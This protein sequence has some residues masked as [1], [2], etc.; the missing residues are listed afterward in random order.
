[1]N[2]NLTKIFL[3]KIKEE[4]T[5]NKD[6]IKINIIK[7]ILDDIFENIS[8]YLYFIFI[9]LLLIII[10]IVINFITLLYYSKIILKKL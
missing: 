9:I 10:L 3:N 5:N 6:D 2:N 1:M 8:H 4:Y 7:P